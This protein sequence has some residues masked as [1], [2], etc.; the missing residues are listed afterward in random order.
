LYGRVGP[1]GG[2]IASGALNPVWSRDGKELFFMLSGG[3]LNRLNGVALAT[4]PTFAFGLPTTFEI[5]RQSPALTPVRNYDLLPDGRF[6]FL[7]SPS[8]Q[9]GPPAAILRFRSW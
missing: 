9:A 2:Q 6:I 8:N 4:Q 1:L 3:V 7:A 5:T